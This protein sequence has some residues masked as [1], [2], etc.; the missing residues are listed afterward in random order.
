MEQDQ[1]AL[2]EFNLFSEQAV[3]TRIESGVSAT[4]KRVSDG[5]QERAVKFS[6]FKP[7]SESSGTKANAFS[8]EKGDI[9]G[10]FV[11]DHPNIIKTHQVLLLDNTTNQYHLITQQ[12]DIPTQNTANYEVRACVLE[13]AKGKELFNLLK[14][15]IIRPSIKLAT[16]V[17]IKICDALIHLHKHG[18]IYRDLKPENI[19]YQPPCTENPVGTVKMVD[20]GFIKRLEKHKL[21]ST[22]CG[23][24]EYFA[25]ERIK[26]SKYSNK[27]DNW[28]VGNLIFEL[29]YGFPP[30]QGASA[31]YT[32]KTIQ[33][34][35]A[36]GE[37]QRR[38]ILI[39]KAGGSFK[40]QHRPFLTTILQLTDPQ[41]DTRMSLNAAKTALENITS[42]QDA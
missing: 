30:L 42:N 7:G 11:P 29:L 4:V 14:E 6:I 41:P 36:R 2:I 18:F 28:A 19:V 21:T 40:E 1:K 37:E 13:L 34:Y 35:A 8:L 38:K 12:S 23:T 3:W 31:I 16:D 39:Q 22:V 20:M 9:L 26:H 15:Q 25:P 5:R 33:N 32:Y 24:P 17:T 27:V 10:L